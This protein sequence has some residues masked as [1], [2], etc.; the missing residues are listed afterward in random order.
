[1][2]Q[3]RT[4]CLLE[5]KM[6]MLRGLDVPACET[7]TRST[8]DWPKKYVSNGITLNCY[9]YI[10]QQIVK[11]DSFQLICLREICMSSIFFF[12]WLNFGTTGSA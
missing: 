11:C 8:I 7:V 6:L 12:Q 2:L 1:V 3:K 10:N 5:L 4:Y 9:P